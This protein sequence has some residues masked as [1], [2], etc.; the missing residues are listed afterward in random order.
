VR[1]LAGAKPA[2]RRVRE[3]GRAAIAPMARSTV[4]VTAVKRAGGVGFAARECGARECDKQPRGGATPSTERVFGLAA[5]VHGCG[6][7]YTDSHAPR[8]YEPP[9]FQTDIACI[10]CWTDG[11]TRPIFAVRKVAWTARSC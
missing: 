5:S 7:E 2:A 10:G 11:L 3:H 6:S 1:G 9:R 8:E 4:V